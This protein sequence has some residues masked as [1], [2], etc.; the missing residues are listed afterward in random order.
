[1]FQDY[2]QTSSLNNNAL[3]RIRE[4][5]PGFD[6]RNE[7][8]YEDLE[9]LKDI[10][11][12]NPRPLSQMTSDQR[13]LASYAPATAL[14][15]GMHLT[16]MGVARDMVRAGH[17]EFQWILDDGAAGELFAFG[18]SE[19]GNDNVLTESSVVVTEVKEGFSFSGEKIFVS[20]S[21]AWSRLSL[22]GQAGDE[23]LHGFITRDQRG[24][25]QRADWDTLGMRATQ[26]Y[27]TVLN[28]VVVN[29]SRL[30]RRVTAGNFDDPFLVSIFQNFLLLVSSVYAGIADR[31]LEIMVDEVGKKSRGSKSESRQADI[32]DARRQVASAAI[33]VDALGPQIGAYSS[34]PDSQSATPAH[35]MRMLSGLKHQSVE[36]AR[37]A[38]DTAMRICGGNAYRSS[39]ELSRLQ[40]DVL[41]GVY[42]PS[43]TDSIHR[44]VALDLFDSNFE[45]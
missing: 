21:P 4:R 40:R 3:Q 34:V 22:L 13:R 6:Q 36:S 30:V 16:W 35:W 7:F 27:T 20:L 43:D 25:S 44:T 42:H 1:M 17:R 18:V 28:G 32:S 31:A 11:Y 26:S 8:F 2:S 10:G 33:D 37:R 5:A 39:H 9:V 12:L 23:I 45:G 15:I 24:W 29:S 14:G 41:A 19:H 38:V